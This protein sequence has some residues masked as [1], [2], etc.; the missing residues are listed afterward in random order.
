MYKDLMHRIV[1]LFPFII[2]RF[3]FKITLNN[4]H[5]GAA[6]ILIFENVTVIAL[7]EGLMPRT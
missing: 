1:P 3:S 7:Y 5:K 2:E 6:C 4:K